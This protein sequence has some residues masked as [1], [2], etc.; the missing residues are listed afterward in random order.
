MKLVGRHKFTVASS[1]YGPSAKGNPIIKLGLDLTEEF[2]NGEWKPIPVSRQMWFGSLG[3]KITKTGKTSAQMT[4]ERLKGVFGFTGKLNELHNLNFSQGECLCE[5]HQEG[6]FT[7]VT[8]IF[9]VGSNPNKGG[10]L[11]ELSTE[12]EDDINKYFGSN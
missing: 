5:D 12:T 10:P 7:R 8:D 3:T 2:V 1:E 4:A 9:A 6:N 11:G